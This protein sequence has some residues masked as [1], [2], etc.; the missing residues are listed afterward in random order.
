MLNDEL[1]PFLLKLVNCGVRFGY[2]QYVKHLTMIETCCRT[3]FIGLSAFVCEQSF[4][5]P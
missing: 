4:S 2:C 5:V 3:P 1:L